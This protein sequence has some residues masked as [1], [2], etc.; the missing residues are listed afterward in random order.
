MSVQETT[1]NGPGSDHP[2]SVLFNLEPLDIPKSYRL[3][4]DEDD[5]GHANGN[6]DIYTPAKA[7]F[8]N[9]NHTCHTGK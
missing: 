9:H 7:M 1:Y 2:C 6:L 4:A 8:G 3:A 5:S